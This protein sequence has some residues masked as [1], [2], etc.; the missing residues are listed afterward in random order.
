M[1]SP[2]NVMSKAS[3]AFDRGSRVLAVKM[4]RDAFPILLLLSYCAGSG[5]FVVA[6]IT[7]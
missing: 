5:M 7:F 3:Q 4:F 6:A 2:L 1:W